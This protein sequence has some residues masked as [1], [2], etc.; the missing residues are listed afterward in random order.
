MKTKT[1]LNCKANNSQCGGKCQPSTN[2]CPSEKSMEASSLLN[3]FVD[4]TSPPAIYHPK[5]EAIL[6][7]A[8][9]NK[10]LIEFYTDLF[11]D[12]E[13]DEHETAAIMLWSSF[14]ED[15]WESI[16]RLRHS[17]ESITNPYLK[18]Y[19]EEAGELLENALKKLKKTK[20]SFGTKTEASQKDDI[21]LQIEKSYSAEKIREDGTVS[22]VLNI[23]GEKLQKYIS[24]FE[25]GE[26]YSESTFMAT[27]ANKKFYNESANIKVIIEPKFKESSGIMIEVFK[28][29]GSEAEVLFPPNTKFEVISVIEET[30]ESKIKDRMEDFSK[31]ELSKIMAALQNNSMAFDS[32]TDFKQALEMLMEI[33]GTLQQTLPKKDYEELAEIVGKL[34]KLD[35]EYEKSKVADKSFKSYKIKL[36]EV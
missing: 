10:D 36:K 31:E 21:D 28:K 3:K 30:P 27:T 12:V 18:E 8:E 13:L 20:L 4:I 14:N 35:L 24:N 23:K 6:E 29:Q 5:N 17:P 2:R 32:P 9:L 34:L 26:L 33:G 1:K 16:N 19:A 11:A 7:F 25:S 22:R 15:D